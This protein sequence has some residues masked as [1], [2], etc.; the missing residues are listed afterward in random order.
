MYY[1][2]EAT[3]KTS[4]VH[5]L[6]ENTQDQQQQPSLFPTS[7]FS[8]YRSRNVWPGGSNSISNNNSNMNMTRSEFHDTPWNSSR[9]PENH[10]CYA[11]TAL[12]LCF[13]IGVCAMIHSVLVDRAWERN[14]FGDAVNHSRQASNYACFG[15]FVGA[16]FWIYWIFIREGNRLFDFNF[17]WFN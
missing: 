2:E 3:G 14:K 16:C 9:R 17:D 7:M 10:Q 12:I 6:A 4:W 1:W 11:V 13:P 5:P 8:G 15:T